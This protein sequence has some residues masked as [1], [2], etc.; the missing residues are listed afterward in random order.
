MA[1]ASINHS[2]G[3]GNNICY[4][5]KKINLVLYGDFGGFEGLVL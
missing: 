4:L 2:L 3:R 5:A 1:E